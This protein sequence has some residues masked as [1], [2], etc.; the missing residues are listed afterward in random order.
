MPGV[1]LAP[2]AKRHARNAIE[3]PMYN[4]TAPM[5][6]S[7]T[8]GSSLRRKFIARLPLDSRQAVEEHA[9]AGLVVDPAARV[10]G[11]MAARQECRG[12]FLREYVEVVDARA[13][14]EHRQQQDVCGAVGRAQ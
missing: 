7:I 11:G 9:P 14:E 6:A 10:D 12:R 5:K 1:R 2:A 3:Q 13:V 8:L 4:I